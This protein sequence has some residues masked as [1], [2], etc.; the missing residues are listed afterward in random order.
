MREFN[1]L[2]A[3]MTPE[4]L[5]E[6]YNIVLVQK[7]VL[8]AKLERLKG[9]MAVAA[10]AIEDGK[11]TPEQARDGLLNLIAYIEAKCT[12]ED[13][14]NPDKGSLELVNKHLEKVKAHYLKKK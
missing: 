3:G 14:L 5:E 2:K 10:C 8:E 1:P 13:E 6:T 7:L 9:E 12:P 4:A 11:L